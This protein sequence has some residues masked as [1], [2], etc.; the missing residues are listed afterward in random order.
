MDLLD[1]ATDK[2]AKRE[3]YISKITRIYTPVVLLLAIAIAILGP[4]IMNITKI[5]HNLFFKLITINS[6]TR[7]CHKIHEC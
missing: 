2:K 3:T 6:V 1:E 5:I 4:M 7:K